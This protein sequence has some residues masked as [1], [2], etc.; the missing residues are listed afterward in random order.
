LGALSGSCWAVND[1][2][3]VG[4][5]SASDTGESA[6]AATDQPAGS[7]RSSFAGSGLATPP[8]FDAPAAADVDGAPVLRFERSA[9]ACDVLD[10]DP[11][12]GF[13][14]S[15]ADCDVLDGD[16][17][18]GFDRSADDGDVLGGDAVV[19]FDRSADDGDALDGAGD[20]SMA[21]CWPV[22]AFARAGEPGGGGGVVAGLDRSATGC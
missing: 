8:D 5:S 3:A 16:P 14:R 10:G 1:P 6:V 15:A 20:R 22:A 17:V 19:G 2:L 18:V 21:A 11:V 12:V 13:D 7:G 4:G 9:D